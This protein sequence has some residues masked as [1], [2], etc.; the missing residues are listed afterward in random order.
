MANRVKKPEGWVG[1]SD[2]FDVIAQNMNG[3]IGYNDD[4][5]VSMDDLRKRANCHPA[6]EE[7]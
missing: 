7:Y 5:D 2:D 6:G 4:T 3:R 1:G